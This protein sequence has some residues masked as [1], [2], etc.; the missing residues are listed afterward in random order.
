MC[1]FGYIRAEFWKHL[2]QMYILN[3]SLLHYNNGHN[4]FIII[5]NRNCE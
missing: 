1:F 2:K 3:W 5:L 4:Y